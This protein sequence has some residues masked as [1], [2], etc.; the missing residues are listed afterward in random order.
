MISDCIAT[1]PDGSSIVHQLRAI[2]DFEL[3][4]WF[5]GSSLELSVGDLGPFDIEV[6]PDGKVW[7][8]AEY[9][10]GTATAFTW[11]QMVQIEPLLRRLPAWAPAVVG[12]PSARS[13]RGPGEGGP[14]ARD[15]G[16]PQGS[17][18]SRTLS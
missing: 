3:P 18:A 16:R 1:L 14:A 17:P 15:P 2:E 9:F 8:S 13:A 12:K 7:L 11:T 10:D 4:A 6:T 5:L